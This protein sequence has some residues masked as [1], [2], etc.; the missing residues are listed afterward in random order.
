MCGGGRRA[1]GGAACAGGGR[2]IPAP[3]RRGP[4]REP[5]AGRPARASRRTRATR[6]RSAVSV[7]RSRCDGRER[8][9]RGGGLRRSDG[10]RAGRRRCPGRST[11]TTGG[12][13]RPLAAPRRQAGP[14]RGPGARIARAAA[15]SFFRVV[16]CPARCLAASSNSLQLSFRLRRL[17]SEPPVGYLRP[18]VAAAGWAGPTPKK[19]LQLPV[20]HCHAI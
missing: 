20:C 7:G 11:R 10:A 18:H 5:S 3:P 13:A 14:G 9:G 16:C 2:L 1:R 15:A 17:S 4:S 19:A 8:D 12:K 6:R